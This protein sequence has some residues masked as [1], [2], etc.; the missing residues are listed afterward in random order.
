M[1]LILETAM[2]WGK[3][4]SVSHVRQMADRLE[5]DDVVGNELRG[6]VAPVC[7][8]DFSVPFE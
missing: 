1:L 3:E 7:S 2:Y 4:R 6:F 8:G 5:E